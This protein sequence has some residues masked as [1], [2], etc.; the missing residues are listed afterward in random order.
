MVDVRDDTVL[1][2]VDIEAV[3]SKVLC[4]HGSGLDDARLLG[5]LTLAKVLSLISHTLPSA[6]SQPKKRTVSF[7]AVSL[8]VLPTSLPCHS[9][10]L[11]EALA[12]GSW[13]GVTRGIVGGGGGGSFDVLE[14]GVNNVEKGKSEWGNTKMDD[15]WMQV[16]YS[17]G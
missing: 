5:Q 7:V 4:D 3:L 6:D 15:G 13:L 8:S 10:V 12:L 14:M 1:F 9:S 11:E 17:S 2:D 16:V